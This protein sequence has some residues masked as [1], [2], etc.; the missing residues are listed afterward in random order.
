MFSPICGRTRTNTGCGLVV[1]RAPVA[2]APVVMPAPPD[3][4][5]ATRRRTRARLGKT[6]GDSMAYDEGLAQILRDDLADHD[7][8]REVR[9]FGGL[10]F[11]KSGHMLC[12]VLKTSGM[13]RVGK[14]RST[15]ALALPGARIMDMTGRKMPAIIEVT[16]DALADDG[17]RAQ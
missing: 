2:I 3:E 14:D 9:M 16:P 10:C 1:M 6:S 11:M 12:G 15:A 5:D 13:F 4:Q 8:L 17:L 7:D